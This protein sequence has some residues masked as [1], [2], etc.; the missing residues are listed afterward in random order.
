MA[1]EKKDGEGALF[2]NDKRTKD[3][4]PNYNG[5]IRIGGVDYWLSGWVK[6]NPDGSFKLLSLS[7][8]PK[9]GR[10]EPSRDDNAIPFD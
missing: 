5:N 9:E 6:K 4:H 2:V 7:A 10:V 1:Y 8:K 3:T